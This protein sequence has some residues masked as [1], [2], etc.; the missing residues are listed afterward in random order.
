MT[1]RWVKTGY[2]MGVALTLA[3]IVYFF[4]SNWQGLD[5][6]TKVSVSIGLMWLFYGAS[7]VLS[8]VMKR[9]D[10]L[11]KWLFVAGAIG[12]GIAVALVGQIYNSHANSFWLF[13]IWLIPSSVLAWMT[14]YEPLRILSVVL[15]QLTFWFYYFPSS[16]QVDQGEW[17]AFVTLFVFALI[18]GIIC[19]FHR[20]AVVPYLAY[21]ALQGWLFVIFQI[22][23]VYDRFT[24]WPYVYA[25]VLAGFL[26][27]FFNIAKRR[28]YILITGLFAGV[29]LIVQYFRF[30]AEYFHGGVFLA[31]LLLAGGLVYGSIQLL[32]RLRKVSTDGAKGRTFMFA[33]QVIVTAVASLIALSSIMGLITIWTNDFSPNV[34]FVLSIVGFVLPA[35]FLRKSNDIVRYTL[36]AVGYGLGAIVS[37]EIPIFIFVSYSI[38][39]LFFY[40]KS[41]NTGVRILTNMA[42]SIYGLIIVLDWTN[43]I[44]LSFLLVLVL[45]GCLYWLMRGNKYER[46][47]PL[48]FGF[49]ALFLLTSMDLFTVDAGY[50]LSNV[51]FIMIVVGFIFFQSK[52]N[53]RFGL[54]I[55][56]FYWWL[57]LVLK[58]YEFAWDLLDKSISLLIS[59][60]LFLAGTAFLEKRRGFIQT[61]QMNWLQPKWRSLLAVVVL[62][63][64]FIGY[65]VFDKEQHL[66]NGEVVKLQLAP[67]DPRSL[68]QGDYVRLRYEISTIEKRDERGSV[69][70][71]LRKDEKGVYRFAGIYSVN[72]KKNEQYVRQKEDVLLNGKMKGDTVI[73][74]IESYFVPEG[75]GGDVQER[76]RFAYVRVSETGDALLEKISDR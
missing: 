31:G 51:S 48:L 74:G 67:V 20:S 7:A 73:Y 60:I 13:L 6:L 59:G 62:Q 11:S 3:S 45:N 46:L 53:E 12:F 56:W 57:F 72:G 76:A 9:Y 29:F 47:F 25:F 28:S 5:R 19:V 23:M 8:Y 21:V 65:V 54:G 27:Y 69:Q 50:V 71:I 4:A 35:I 26:Y 22:S 64:I 32:K 41:S 34:L 36:L 40:L 43:E 75:T 68:L 37:W 66:R 30:V 61:E 55:A 39:L 70:I 1:E 38:A 44:R 24:G 2:F 49:G 10:F 58:Y 63:T 42:L 15:L 14:R 17:E 16:Y 33:F 18:N 52:N